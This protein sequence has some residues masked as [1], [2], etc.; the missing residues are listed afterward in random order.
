MKKTI[1][2][3]LLFSSVLLSACGKD[4]QKSV[5]ETSQTSTSQTKQATETSTTTSTDSSATQSNESSS[6]SST[7]GEETVASNPSTAQS[8]IDRQAILNLDFTSLA[9]TWVNDRGESVT[10][11]ANGLVS[12]EW[13]LFGPNVHE[14]RDYLH[15][16]YGHKETKGSSA[17]FLVPKGVS[18]L[19]GRVF[20]QDVLIIGQSSDAEEHPYYK[21]QLFS[22]SA[23]AMSDKDGTAIYRLEEKVQCCPVFQLELKTH[24][25]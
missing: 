5:G 18:T 15:F 6:P 7:A 17:M 8:G 25:G 20:E 21:Q 11:N 24:D 16:T 14:N 22:R 1:L 4:T 12:E 2:F 10:F 13:E 9:G 19:G 3:I 23:K